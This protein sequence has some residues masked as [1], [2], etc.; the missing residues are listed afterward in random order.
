M[1]ILR[2][3]ELISKNKETQSDTNV[4]EKLK[5]VMNIKLS[6]TKNYYTKKVLQL[7]LGS[8]KKF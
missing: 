2:F 4:T 6:I 3:D 7:L 1:H 5:C 8:S